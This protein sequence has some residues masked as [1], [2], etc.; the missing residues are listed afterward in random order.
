MNP[1]VLTSPSET[2]AIAALDDDAYM[3]ETC[4]KTIELRDTAA[5]RL[6][7]MGIKNFPS[8]TNFLLIDVQSAKVANDLDQVL[9]AKGIFL[10]PQGGVGLPHCL[11]MT[12]GPKA[13]MDAALSVI[14]TA[15]KEDAR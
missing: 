12:V 10:R 7:A 9:R 11:R 3:R 8:F 15:Q 4:I 6:N 2:A 14:E 1:N 13:H 5:A